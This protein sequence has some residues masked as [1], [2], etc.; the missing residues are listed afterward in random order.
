MI[1]LFLLLNLVSATFSFVSMYILKYILD[2]L[3]GKAPDI[4][5]V[6]LFVALYIISLVLMHALA[7]VRTV[8]YN[9]VFDKASHKYKAD[10][11]EKLAK[12]PMSVL[13]TSEGRDMIDDVRYTDYYA[14]HLA[15]RLIQ[16]FTGLYSFIVAFSALIIFDIWFSLLFLA[17]TV[18]GI[19]MDSVF[20]RKAEA[21]RRKTAPDLRRF[22][23]YRWMLTDAWPAKDVRMY[24]L[25]EPIK[26]RYDTEKDNYRQANKALDIKKLR[27]SLLTETIRRAGEI[28]FTVFVLIRAIDG[29]LSIGDIA[30]YTGFALSAT[31]D[32]ENMT[33]V[34]LIICLKTTKMLERFFEFMNIKC[35][36]ENNVNEKG[37]RKLEAF[38]SLTFDNVYFKYPLTEKNVLDGASFT[39]NKGDR[40]SIIGVNGSGKSTVIKLMLGLYQVDSGQILINGYPMS[41]YDIKDVRKLFSVLFQSF[42][43]YP[44]TLRDNI[45]LSDPERY[46]ND[47]EIT[48]ALR[49]SGIY[50]VSI[51]DSKACGIFGN[52]LDSNMTRQFDDKGIELSKGQ[53]QK[54]A[55][56]RAYFKNAPVIIFD[57][58]SAALDAEAE[59]KIFRNFEAI[60]ENKTGIM[61]SHRISSAKM[62]N[63]IIVL[64]GG[65][66]AESGTHEELVAIN[67]LYA[68]LYN[69]QLQKYT[70]KEVIS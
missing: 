45:A 38:E 58:P 55:L 49:Q 41:D 6:I 21:L 32:F 54:I 33:S 64:D 19:I 22:C 29:K 61:I 13:D 31:N 1:L 26:K 3:T 37:K 53:W 48:E 36:D 27:A 69:L 30:L 7:S 10:L 14:V 39:L 17:L 2:E 42:V 9:S 25:T 43:Q 5:A 68:K 56:S 57:E 24:D 11:S 67:G 59:D 66:I 34:V 50:D 8:L 23:Y 4:N 20:D 65:K 62:S 15:Y 70:V 44:L 51:D 18:P 52:G 47:A 28:I 40:L 35:P 63:K 60:S 16:I 12:L 46:D